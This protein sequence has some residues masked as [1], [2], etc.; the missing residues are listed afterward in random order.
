MH[1]R[2]RLAVLCAALAACQSHAVT[3]QPPSS[4]SSSRYVP[5]LPV[6]R[7][8]YSDVHAGFKERIAQPYAFVECRG[9]Y[10]DTGRA[11]PGLFDALR[12]A[13][14]AAAGPP[15][16]LFFDDPRSAPAEVLR[17]RACVPIESTSAVRDIATD[18]LPQATV[19][20][21]LVAGPY[22][23]AGLA[24]AGLRAYVSRMGWI[25][26]GPIREVYLVSPASVQSYGDLVCEV[27]MPVTNAP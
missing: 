8:P 22:P 10:R 7:A 9:S 21:A 6:T 12:R 1:S 25:V 14:V 13:G 5:D 20:Y 4:T 26:N 11:L 3:A 16:A 2:S 19:A 24:H 27:Q 23:D 18:L 15:F 17:S